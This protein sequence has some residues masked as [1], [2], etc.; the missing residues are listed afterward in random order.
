MARARYG[1]ATPAPF[2]KLWPLFFLGLFLTAL[3]GQPETGLA[4]SGWRPDW[5]FLLTLFL[6]L[7]AELGL[8]YGGAFFFGLFQGYPTLASPGLFSLKLM[9]GVLIARG[10]ASKLEIGGFFPLTILALTLFGAL[11]VGLEPWL[12]NLTW[13]FS[14]YSFLSGETLV[15]SAREGLATAFF[16]G[17]VFFVL[18]R[19]I[20]PQ[21]TQ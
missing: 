21:D 14:R 4:L 16:V 1:P 20:R 17:P 8:A 19:L 15:L 12:L 13:P 3:T 2:R 18:D 7:R 9:V 10:I 5:P 11:A 6:A